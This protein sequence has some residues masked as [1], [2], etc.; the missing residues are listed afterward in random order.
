MFILVIVGVTVAILAVWRH[1]TSVKAARSA[2]RQRIANENLENFSK[3]L[4]VVTDGQP[5]AVSAVTRD[6]IYT[7]ANARAAADAEGTP[8]THEEM[9]GSTM[10]SV[11]G[12]IRSK[13]YQ[14]IN[15]QVLNSQQPANQIHRFPAEDGGTR[16]VVSDHIYLNADRK[17][18]EGVLMI[19]QDVTEVVQE[20]ERRERTMRALVTMLVGLV[21]R[22]DP[23]SADQSQ[24]VAEVSAAVAEEMGEPEGTQRT[25]D[26]AGNLMNL[27]K[28]LVPPEILTKTGALSEEEAELVRQSLLQTADMVEQV[29]FDFPVSPVL[30]HLQ[31]RYDGSGY[32][33]GLSGDEIEMGARIISVANAFVGMVSPRAWR[34]ALGFDEA[35]GQLMG[36]SGERYDP[37]PV[38]ALINVIN[39]RGGRE[40]WAHF[41]ETPESD[42][43]GG[44]S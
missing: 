9:I 22:R 25:V 21:D 26:V 17:F 36:D 38:A 18:P 16:T 33:D 35:A 1:G 4:R 28:I 11:I 39:N 44:D 34:Q 10:A 43:D 23:F 27:G 14:E 2:E 3:F 7:F 40:S 20:R 19:V 24:R 8:I 12:P 42:G 30:R 29:N 41:R 32:P 13:V 6:G 37:R 5:T 31:E 15:E